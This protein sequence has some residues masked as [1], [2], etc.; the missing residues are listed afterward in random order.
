MPIERRKKIRLSDG[1]QVWQ[2]TSIRYRDVSSGKFV[3]DEALGELT[4]DVQ[5]DLDQIEDQILSTLTEVATDSQL[6]AKSSSS[7][8]MLLEMVEKMKQDTSELEGGEWFI[9]GMDLAKEVLA[10]LEEDG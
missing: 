3:S 7:V 10:L 4:A 5:P 8:R 1:R 6:A 9:L 2:S